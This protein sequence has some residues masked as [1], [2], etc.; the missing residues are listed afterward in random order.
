MSPGIGMVNPINPG[1][2]QMIPP[3]GQGP[4]YGAF[5]MMHHY[6]K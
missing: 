4:I 6:Q 3:G 5:P 1:M 2:F